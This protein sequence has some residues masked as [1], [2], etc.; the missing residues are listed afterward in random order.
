MGRDQEALLRVGCSLFLD[1]AAVHT[2][3]RENDRKA[4]DINGQGCLLALMQGK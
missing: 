4:E 2:S 3:T 1:S